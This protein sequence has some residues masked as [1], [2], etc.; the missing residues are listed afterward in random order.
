MGDTNHAEVVHLYFNP[1]IIP[2]K[3]LLNIF[4]KNHNPTTLNRQGVDEGT[5]YRSIVFYH[6][7]SQKEIF[8]KSI[9]EHAKKWENTIVTQVFP[10]TSFYRA[11]EYHQDYL[12]KNNLGSCR[13]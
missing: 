5:Q 4:W 2:Y 1:N 9:L 12:N 8:E 11:E 3:T 7:D 13:L 6:S 10:A